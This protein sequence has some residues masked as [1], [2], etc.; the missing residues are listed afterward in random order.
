MNESKV[1]DIDNNP[2]GECK[3]YN[4]DK[5]EFKCGVNILVGCNGS[6]KT[7]LMKQIMN[8]LE[9][10]EI[11]TW[12][13]FDSYRKQ[14]ISHASY[15]DPRALVRGLISNY[16]SEGEGI[17]DR[18]SHFAEELG[19]FVRDVE[20]DEAWIFWDSI[21]SGM[22]IDNINE[23]CEFI[24]NTLLK[25]LPNNLKMYIVISSNMYELANRYKDSCID[26]IN[27][28]NIKFKDYEDYRDFIM[29][30]RKMK[31]KLHS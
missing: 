18:I 23:V 12:S 4:S 29:D 6:G 7:T 28:K 24:D 27:L 15:Q 10:S 11:S 16:Q 5:V 3:I 2:Y 31:L 26:V 14:E 25:T 30:S 20:G 9:E 19:E 22:S 8:N 21:D 17:I 13:Y 1:L